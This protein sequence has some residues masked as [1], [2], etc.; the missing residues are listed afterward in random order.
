MII[1]IDGALDTWMD[2]LL[3]SLL[4]LYPLPSGLEI[5]SGDD[6][7]PPRVSM[8]QASTKLLESSVDPL[9]TD[10]YYHIAAVKCNR[11]ITAEDWY[12]DVRHLEFDFANN[13]QCVVS[14]CLLAKYVTS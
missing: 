12:Q 5:I 11:R 10:E 8:T 6:L 1:R 7:P 14:S 3:E 2:Q 4:R 9:G 13:I